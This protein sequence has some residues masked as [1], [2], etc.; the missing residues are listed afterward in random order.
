[1]AQTVTNGRLR[2]VL[3]MTTKFAVALA[4]IAIDAVNR[5]SAGF[6]RSIREAL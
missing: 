4:V 6:A 1:M 3:V 5:G 2:M